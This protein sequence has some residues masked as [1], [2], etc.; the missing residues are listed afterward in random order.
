MLG[1]LHT[2]KNKDATSV[3]AITY[4]RILLLNAS[5]EFETLLITDHELA[6]LRTRVSKNE[7]DIAQPSWL[8]KLWKTLGNLF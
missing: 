8:D 6:R 4:N 1:Q 7:E 2:H 3:H 5:G